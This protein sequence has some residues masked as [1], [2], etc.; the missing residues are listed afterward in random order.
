MNPIEIKSLK[1]DAAKQA[2]RLLAKSFIDNPVS[3]HV[4]DNFT[5][6]KREN[7]LYKLYTGLVNTAIDCGVAEAIYLND[8]LAGISLAYPPGS[9][10]F[11]IW[12]WVRN[13]IGGMFLGV[14]YTWRLALLDAVIRKKHIHEKHWYLFV[15]GV[16]PHLQGKGLGGRLV[17]KMSEKA[18]LNAMPCYLET[19]KPENINFYK[20][21]GYQL[22]GEEIIGSLNNLKIWYMMRPAKG[23]MRSD[24]KRRLK[25]VMIGVR[26]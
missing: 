4:F 9:Y 16:A 18:D 19:D 22:I 6:E 14:K 26:S 13:G 24:R 1:T 25:P 11:S 21:Q 8:E 23:Q 15:L 5:P 12:T 10:P 20:S 2:T 3:V 7:K 17:S